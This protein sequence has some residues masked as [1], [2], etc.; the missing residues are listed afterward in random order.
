MRVL[1]T[2]WRGLRLGAHMALGAVLA[3]LRPGRLDEGFARGWSRAACRILGLRVVVNGTPSGTPA[4]WVA[5]HVS[6]LEVLALQTV[7]PL[8]F[9]AKSEVA[10][11]PVVGT[12]AAAA[13]TLFL[14]RGSARAASRTAEAALLRLAEGRSVAAFPEGTSTAGEEVLEFKPALFEAPARLGC[15]VQP[16]SVYY[17]RPDGSRAVAP[18]IGDDEFLPHLLRVLAEPEVVVVL[19][20][21][22][23]FSGHGRG[24]EELARRSRDA[25]AASLD[26]RR[27]GARSVQ[28]G[29]TVLRGAVARQDAGQGLLGRVGVQDGAR[30]VLELDDLASVH[31]MGGGRDEV[32]QVAHRPAVHLVHGEQA[33]VVIAAVDLV[34]QHF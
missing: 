19:D 20:L 24:R 12:I 26:A 34:G 28:V 17:P 1:R 18:F 4:L 10:R 15:E 8:G 32:L 7:A 13:G 27:R 2:A 16:V 25:V 30:A 21:R 11:W 29:G 9:V 33:P 31:R 5:N 22:P 23:A 6:W 14:K 3:V